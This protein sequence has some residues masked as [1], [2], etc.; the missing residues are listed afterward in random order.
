MR[1]LYGDLP[2]QQIADVKKS[3]RGSI[4]FLLLCVDPETSGNYKGI[5]VNK[6][7]ENLLYRLDGFNYLLS[8]P[9][10]VVDVMCLIQAA[11][12][13]YNKPIFNFRTYRKLI[14]DAGAQVLKIGGE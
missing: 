7:F 13:I 12:N 6:T 9:K 11:Q 8:Y 10:E 14:L 2:E 4:Y 1:Y 5:D 3:I